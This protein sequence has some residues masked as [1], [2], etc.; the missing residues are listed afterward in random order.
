MITSPGSRE[1]NS[2]VMLTD[3]KAS[4]KGQVFSRSRNNEND[5]PN[6]GHSSLLG[7][8]E[9]DNFTLVIPERSK[10]AIISP[11]HQPH[12]GHELGQVKQEPDEHAHDALS[13]YEDAASEDIVVSR[14]MVTVVL[15]EKPVNEQNVLHQAPP[16]T[17]AISPTSSPPQ[18]PRPEDQNQQRPRTASPTKRN[19]DAY[20]ST[21]PVKRNTTTASQSESPA[22]DRAE[23]LKARRL[24]ASGTERVRTRTLDAH[25]YRR[26]QDLIK[27]H[28]QTPDLK[29]GPLLN[30]LVESLTA[31]ATPGDTNGKTY[32]NGVGLKGQALGAIKAVVSLY[33]R[34][35]EEI[36]HMVPSVLI[37]FANAAGT[38][39]AERIGSALELEKAADEVVTKAASMD[40]DSDEAQFLLDNCANAVAEYVERSTLS[41]TKGSKGQNKAAALAITIL[42]RLIPRIILGRRSRND[43]MPEVLR[44]R[45]ARLAVRSLSDLDPDIRRKG[46]ELA[47]EL[48][49]AFPSPEFDG[50][51][52]KT[53]PSV[54]GKQEFWTL[55][56]PAGEQSC[57][58]LA[59][60]LARRGRVGPP[61]MS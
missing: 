33:A 28:V 22:I 29:F 38:W 42:A 13:V 14:E 39:E 57:N 41:T 50:T 47:L 48:Y 24:L 8:V 25:G 36:R 60:Y 26:L 58:L 4:Q 7:T 6:S 17:L 27:T 23:V 31:L 59:Y 30:A 2:T 54:Q 5:R 16:E 3:G 56:K 45:L 51:E 9:E 61:S 11:P 44:K 40:S 19:N 10:Y 53:S 20:G 37:G 43:T 52:D 21:S 35:D 15:E 32:G 49:A 46:V 55:L 12:S 18:P 1:D 34:R